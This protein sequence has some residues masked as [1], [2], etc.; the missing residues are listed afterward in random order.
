VN[1]AV[2]VGSPVV[3]HTPNPSYVAVVADNQQT[4]DNLHSYFERVGIASSGSRE[5]GN[6][7]R[8]P[9]SVAALVLFPDDF[10][11]RAVEAFILALR[12]SRPKL[13]ILLVTSTPQHLGTAVEPDGR[14]VPPLVLPRPAFG[15][16]ILDAIRARAPDPDADYP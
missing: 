2:S 14:S 1:L 5:L 9:S 6:A 11:R 15:W 3:S 10:E 12:S 16:T 7:A 13:L 8:L 4:L